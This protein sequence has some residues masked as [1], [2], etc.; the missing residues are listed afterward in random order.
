MTIIFYIL[1]LING[2]L[3]CVPT[4]KY[5]QPL[6]GTMPVEIVKPELAAPEPISNQPN[7]PVRNRLPSRPKTF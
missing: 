7:E 3:Y 6:P 1:I 4:D 2:I 5:G